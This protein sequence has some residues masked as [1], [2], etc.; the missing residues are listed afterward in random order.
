[1]K[2]TILGCNSA[3]PANGRFPTAQ[4]LQVEDELF[5]IDC[6]EGT[7]MRMNEHHIARGKINHIFISHL[8]GDHVFG[9][10]GLLTSYSLNQR[11]EALH[12]YAPAG[13][14]KM[15]EVQVKHTGS[16]LSYPI[17]F[18]VNDTETSTEIFI[19][20]KIS[21]TTI[22]LVHRV[23]CCGFLFKEQPKPLN[24]IADKI[25]E[26]HIDYQ[27]IKAIKAGADYVTSDGKTIS[28]SELTKPPK[29]QRSYA[30]CS[31]TAY[32]EAVIPIIK[33]ADLLYHETTFMHDMKEWATKTG[34]ST[35]RQAAMI[36]KQAGVGQLICGHYSSRFKDLE[37]L[38]AEAREVFP[39][40]ELGIEGRIFEF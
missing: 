2:L 3:V 19:N 25:K 28:N 15:V 10:M 12:I 17:H 4:V 36:A 33:N 20:K 34:H 26:Y 6:G 9:L 37:P 21:V 35:A 1:M 16:Y 30:F 5:L 40:T 32:H 18:H 27:Q 8:H 22:P 13:L 31:D 39:N 23:P 14:R 11:E 7:Q 24:I 38:L 29:P